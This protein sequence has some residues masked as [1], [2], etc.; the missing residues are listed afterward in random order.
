MKFPYREAVGALVQTVTMIQPDIA[1]AVRAV[2]RFYPG[3]AH[4]KALLKVMFYLFR[5]KELLR[6]DRMTADW[7]WFD[8]WV[9][10]HPLYSGRCLG[11]L[12]CYVGHSSRIT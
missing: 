2:A 7:L 12:I 5:T 6:S 8:G 4:K 10:F 3:L 9:R 1:C 11:N